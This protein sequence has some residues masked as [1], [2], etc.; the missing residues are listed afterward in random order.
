M[1]SNFEQKQNHKNNLLDNKHLLS[2]KEGLALSSS[3]IS[4]YL[5]NMCLLQ[6]VGGYKGKDCAFFF[7]SDKEVRETRNF[8]SWRLE[9][10]TRLFASIM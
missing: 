2:S 9:K 8:S 10:P 5:E 4:F 6:N 3:L 1:F 7:L